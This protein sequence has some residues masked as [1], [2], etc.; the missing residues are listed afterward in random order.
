M[1]DFLA[2]AYRWVGRGADALAYL[3]IIGEQNT[4]VL[5]VVMLAASWF[6]RSRQPAVRSII[7]EC[8]LTETTRTVRIVRRH[9]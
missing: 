2:T 4:V 3:P 1:A 7:D 5:F 8:T 9:E 6:V